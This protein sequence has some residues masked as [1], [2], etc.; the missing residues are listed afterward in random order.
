MAERDGIID[1]FRALSV[2]VVVG[3]HSVVTSFTPPVIKTIF[4]YEKYNF[5]YWNIGAP[6]F[7]GHLGV[8]IF[9][10]IS[11]YVMMM[12]SRNDVARGLS[13]GA[14]LSLFG[15]AISFWMKRF[16][17]IYPMFFIHIT[18]LAILSWHPIRNVV[19]SYLFATNFSPDTIVSVSHVMW[20]LVVEM[21]F[22]IFFPFLFW[23]V[24]GRR[25]LLLLLFVGSFP[26]VQLMQYQLV[27]PSSPSSLFILSNNLPGYLSLFLYGMLLYEFGPI[28]G[29]IWRIRAVKIPLIVIEFGLFFWN[30]DRS[31]LAPETIN[32]L[33]MTVTVSALIMAMWDFGEKGEGTGKIIQAVS[34]VGRASY[35]IYLF[36]IFGIQLAQR[37]FGGRFGET[38]LAFICIIF[39]VLS[40]IVAYLILERPIS[41]LIHARRSKWIASQGVV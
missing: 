13:R 33:Y 4:D 28:L 23:M 32:F 29:R 41:I 11:G 10:C 38:P 1:S 26:L 5:L 15:F 6:L 16:L 9:F 12:V 19:L 37:W 24:R 20:S 25:I 7:R 22:Y 3:V 2:L 40:G 21:Q 27:G 39:G 17:R 30:T 31:L 18:L 34:F 35:S 14:P 8:E 36:H